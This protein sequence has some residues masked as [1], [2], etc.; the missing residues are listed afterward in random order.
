MY[1][2]IHDMTQEHIDQEEIDIELAE[3]PINNIPNHE[4]KYYECSDDYKIFESII[5]IN[6]DP[7]E[8]IGR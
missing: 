8:S 7:P 6:F 5:K 3:K 1:V 2:H 4:P